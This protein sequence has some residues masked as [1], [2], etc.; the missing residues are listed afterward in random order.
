M[1]TLGKKDTNAYQVDVTQN[2]NQFAVRLQGKYN[3]EK[4]VKTLNEW[5]YEHNCT[6]LNFNIT[7]DSILAVVKRI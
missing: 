6:L 7:G 2:M 5:C 3:F 1:F 4:D